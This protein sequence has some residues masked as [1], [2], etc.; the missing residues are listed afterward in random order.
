MGQPAGSRTAVGK[1]S[2]A[3]GF[4]AADLGVGW[5]R[6]ALLGLCLVV[7]VSL[8][9]LAQ[10][11]DPGRVA[12]DEPT[13]PFAAG[14]DAFDR[15]D[16][17]KAYAIWL[18]WAHRGDPAAQRNLAH[19]YRMGL[20]VPQNFVQ[21]A[22]WYRLAAESGL[23]RAQAN[24][25][26]MYLRGQGVEEDAR[27]AAYWFAVAATNGHALA[28]FNLA[29]LYLRGTGV[30][31]N[32][33]KAAGWLYLAAKAGYRPAIKA[34]A[35]LVPAISGP[36]GPPGPVRMA[37]KPVPADGRPP[38]FIQ[39]S[40]EFETA[41]PPAPPG[42]APAKAGPVVV[43]AMTAPA[44]VEDKSVQAAP[45]VGAPPEHDGPI[46]EPPDDGMPEPVV[47]YSLFGLL[48][49]AFSGA[50]DPEPGPDHD[51][52]PVRSSEEMAQRGIAAGLVALHAGNFT[53]AKAR[54]QPLATH[55]YA[56][57]QYQLGELYLH[58]DYAGAS[59]VRGFFW[60]SR[61]AAQQHAGALARKAAL[62]SVISREERLAARQLAQKFV[63]ESAT[64]P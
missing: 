6:S 8:P 43:Q 23:A 53:A 10:E 16:F 5:L 61:A 7:S 20:G 56:E 31:R 29:L 26:S 24:L 30:E 49:D 55:G 11:V 62:D 15:G 42:A 34:L 35:R 13:Q 48:A 25:A 2:A 39:D 50:P 18:P 27:E 3:K 41:T 54:W 38:T 60:L 14:V 51:G 22:A 63:P 52:S 58:E 33:A 21:A 28:Q 4:S 44:P 59:R 36:A 17:V 46:Y 12:N 1:S 9:V 57:A 37:A 40:P 19:L 47:E 64:R 45:A 32:E